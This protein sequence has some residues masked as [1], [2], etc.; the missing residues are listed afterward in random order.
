FR[1]RPT[2]KSVGLRVVDSRTGNHSEDDFM[3]LETIRRLYSVF[4][5]RSHLGFEWETSEPKGRSIFSLCYLFRNPFSSTTIGDENHIRT[6][7]DYSKPSHEGYRNTIELPVGNNVVPLRYDTIRLVQ[8][9]CS[10]HG[11]WP[12]D[13]NQHLKDFLKLVDS[14]DL[15]G[16]N[17]ERTRLRLFQFSLCDQASNWLKRLPN[18][19]LY[20]NESWNDPRDFAKPVKAIALPQDVLSTSDSRLIE[21]R[22]LM[23]AHLAPRQPTQVNK[24]TT[25]CEI[26][27]SPH[28]TQYCMEDLEQAFI[29]YV[30]SRTD[31]AGGPVEGACLAADTM[32]ALTIGISSDSSDES[33][34]SPSSRVILFG[35][36]PTVIPATSVIAPETPAI[37]LVISFADRYVTTVARWRSRAA[38]RSSSPS[39]FPISLITAPP[40]TRCSRLLTDLTGGYSFRVDL[41]VL[42]YRPQRAMTTRKSVGPLPARKIALRHLSPRSSDHRPSSSSSPTGSSPVHSSN[43]DAPDQAHFGSSTRVVSPRLGYP[44]RRAP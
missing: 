11:L 9:G 6:L 14:L 2:A 23:E 31:E 16:E 10:F 19:A 39:D 25:S 36:I 22:H 27:S 5:R 20:D 37:A 3:P 15:D 44:S 35:D 33:V 18:L 17:R 24:V 32:A 21:L 43:L 41:T 40:G 12:E 7:G 34:G 28:D 8:N 13:P 42:T 30:S 1:R 38:T 4:G 26:C 29:E